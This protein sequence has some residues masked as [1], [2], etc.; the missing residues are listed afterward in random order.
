LSAA[1]LIEFSALFRARDKKSAKSAGNNRRRR[2]CWGEP[3]RD[4]FLPLAPIGV[5]VYFLA[6]PG[7][8]S[9]FGTVIGWANRMVH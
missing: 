8:L 5:V 1:A 2:S 7:H 9:I 6:F 3:M 4:W